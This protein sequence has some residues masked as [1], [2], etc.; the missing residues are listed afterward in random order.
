VRKVQPSLSV[1]KAQQT[2][3]FCVHEHSKNI[4]K[5]IKV[6]EC[7]NFKAMAKTTYKNKRYY[8]TSKV[9]NKGIRKDTKKKKY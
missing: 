2:Y 9:F 1:N 6:K 5:F 3:A 4:D 8:N 7:D